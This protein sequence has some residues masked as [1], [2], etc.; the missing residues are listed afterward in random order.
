MKP[1]EV[2]L[3]E[4]RLLW[5]WLISGSMRMIVSGVDVTAS[6]IRSLRREIAH[7]EKR[8]ARRRPKA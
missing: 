3:A 2:D 5:K 4:R 8:L 7:L 6:H 1:I